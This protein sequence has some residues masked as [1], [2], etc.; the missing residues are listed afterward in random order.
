M[1]MLNWTSAT[2]AG[3]MT[4][5]ANEPADTTTSR[6]TAR[7][8]MPAAGVIDGQR[9]LRASGD[10]HAG[11]QSDCPYR[12]GRPPLS[13]AWRDALSF[14]LA[15]DPPVRQAVLAQRHDALHRGLLTVQRRGVTV[16]AFT[17]T[18]VAEPV[19]AYRVLAS[20]SLGEPAVTHPFH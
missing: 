8:V 9:K 15:D 18:R 3:S 20:R 10:G 17:S 7:R 13:R 11:A 19:D 2:V 4:S 12:A 6:T 16:L 5:A 1:T 14:K